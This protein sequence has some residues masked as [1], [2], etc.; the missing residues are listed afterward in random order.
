[1]INTRKNGTDI[2]LTNFSG[3]QNL[4]AAYYVILKR[5]SIKDKELKKQLE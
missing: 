2:F 5:Q 4:L 3:Q 1:M